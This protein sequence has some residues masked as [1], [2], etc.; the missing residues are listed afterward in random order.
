M[1]I[2]KGNVALEIGTGASVRILDKKTY[3]LICRNSFVNLLQ[4]SSK[5]TSYSG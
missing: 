1:K 5:L 4:I 3:D 2:E